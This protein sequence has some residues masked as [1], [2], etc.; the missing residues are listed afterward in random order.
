MKLLHIVFITLVSIASN[1]Q[2][3]DSVRIQ[4]LLDSAAQLRFEPTKCYPIFDVA[5][6]DARTASNDRWMGKVLKEKGKMFFYYSMEDSC[7][8]TWRRALE[9]FERSGSLKNQAA[10]LNNLGAFCER[11]GKYNKGLD[12]HA[13]SIQIKSQIGDTVGVGTSYNN[14]GNIYQKLNEYPPAIR[15][16]LKADSIHQSASNRPGLALVQAN[17]SGVYKVLNQWDKALKHGRS[18]AAYFASVG[19]INNL[20]KS[21]LGLGALHRNIG[22]KDSAMLFVDSSAS[23]YQMVN[24]TAAYYDCQIY[25]AAIFEE[26]GA[27]EQQEAMADLVM[28]VPADVPLLPE[29][30]GKAHL[31]KVACYV[32]R[33]EYAKALQHAEKANQYYTRGE[34][35]FQRNIMRNLC[36]LYGR[37]NRLDEADECCRLYVK[38]RNTLHEQ[39][40]EAAA[41]RQVTMHEFNLEDK[42]K[43]LAA[44]D[45]ARIK[46]ELMRRR[47]IETFGA[48][49]AALLLLVLTIAGVRS[50]R[51]QRKANQIIKEQHQ[52]VSKQKA[53]VERRNT[54]IHDALDLGKEIQNNIIPN[55]QLLQTLLPNHFALYLPKDVVAGDFYWMHDDGDR[56]FLAAADC[57]GH[58]VP[59]AMVSLICSNALTKAVTELQLSDPG[60]ILDQA[61]ST[62]VAEFSKGENVKDGMDICLVALS[63]KTRELSFAGANNPLY[64]MSDDWKVIKGDKEPIGYFENPTPFTTHRIQL[65][66]GD[67]FYLFTD[68]F[69][70]QFGGSKGKKLKYKPFR[71]FLQSISNLPMSDQH[72]RLAAFFLEW[73]GP[74]EQV[75]DVCVLSVKV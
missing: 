37:F 11:S 23:L 33:E 68:G 60:K 7:E 12:Y 66:A 73:R 24:N 30:R 57:T 36:S 2:S 50:I 17:M 38:L 71:E 39:E 70:D 13:R 29:T 19:D 20:A 47:K 28:A 52:I 40:H 45:Q 27:F 1:G 42:K 25:R 53:E 18:A 4:N 75:D 9:Y 26:T 14:M 10:T 35:E 44:R 3:I 15:C 6:G 55:P 58:G 48:Y 63:K 64:I 56:V 34:I 62:V 43:A 46:E 22:N 32:R 61:R 74:N 31:H 49:G 41:I 65:N 67:Q 72:D 8:F 16:Y 69:A 21:Q 5:F 59:G 54:A 51:T